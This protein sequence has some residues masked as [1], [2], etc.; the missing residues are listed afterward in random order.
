MSVRFLEE[1]GDQEHDD[2]VEHCPDAEGPP[3]AYMITPLLGV[4][5]WTVFQKADVL[6]ARDHESE[7]EWC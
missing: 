1:E 5:S 7:Y 4:A 6:C 3:P 2:G